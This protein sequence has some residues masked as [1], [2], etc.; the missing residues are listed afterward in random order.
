M[1]EGPDKYSHNAPAAGTR[2]RMESLPAGFGIPGDESGA[3]GVAARMAEKRHHRTRARQHA[4]CNR[5][6]NK[7]ADPRGSTE[8]NR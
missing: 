3:S 6:P 7:S 1:A 2:R 5:A 8:C 4:T